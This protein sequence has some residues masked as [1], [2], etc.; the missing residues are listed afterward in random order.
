MKK[1]TACLLVLV[2][3]VSTV[4]ANGNGESS[5]S[6]WVKKVD[7]VV[8]AKAGGGT[9]LMA[10]AIFQNVAKQ[11]G[12]NIGIINN[13]TGNAVVAMEE[14]RNADKD[15][16]KILFYNGGML[17]RIAAGYYN[18][19]IDE[20]TVLGVGHGPEPGYALLV[21]GDSGMSTI[22]DV[23]AKAKEK[24][25]S[26]LF[27]CNVGGT[28]QL[29]GAQLAEALGV[30][31]KYVASGAD[32]NT[33]T[34]L[35]GHSIDI[36]YAN[37]NQARQYVESGKAIAI[38]VL[39]QSD[40]VLTSPLLPDVPSMQEL[41]YDLKFIVF[42]LIMGPAGMDEG[43]AKQIYEYLTVALADE[44]VNNLLT[45]AGLATALYGFEE[46]REILA[47]ETEKYIEIFERYGL[48]K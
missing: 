8:P 41:G 30:E 37:I 32:T 1:F 21:A 2:L 35:V 6:D 22:D 42:S 40:D 25:G 36:C 17:T 18:H 38:G 31:F 16:S 19:S 7:I 27:G 39:P 12:N 13:E 9:D 46:G 3:A 15:G 4:F 34:E 47:E 14:V 23:I 10:R 26:M 43:L 44:E 20:F 28:T 33:L 45:P 29:M 11:A 5:G 48:K 24:N